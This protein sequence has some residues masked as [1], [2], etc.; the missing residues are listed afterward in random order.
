[1]RLFLVAL[2]I[3]V[4]TGLLY[5]VISKTGIDK[6]STMLQ[7]I[8]L[9][10][11]LTACLIY[12]ISIYVSSIRWQLFLPEGFGIK[13]LFSLYLIGSFFNNILP[14]VIG[15]DAVKAYYVN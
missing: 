1:M 15:G 2:K 7:G 12:T 14:G 4:S 6:V 9:P 13:R 8:S 11:F 5:V 3:I 10:Y